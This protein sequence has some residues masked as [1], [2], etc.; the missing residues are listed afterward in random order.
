[1]NETSLLGAR[2]PA[3]LGAAILVAGLLTGC[4]AAASGPPATGDPTVA[5]VPTSAASARVTPTPAAT[6]A[7]KGPLIR[8]DTTGEE[9]SRFMLVW[10]KC[11]STN[12]VPGIT[13]EN[14]S[15]IDPQLRTKYSEAWATCEGKRPE[16]VTERFKREHPQAFQARLKKFITCMKNDGQKIIFIPPDGWGVSDEQAEAGY[17][18]SEQSM[19][20]C[21]NRAYGR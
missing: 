4:S 18:P 7:A 9:I 21:E 15:K 10:G 16:L 12:G 14:S 20:K 3:R 5:S 11:L 17:T 2:K 6:T 8:A 13:K 19:T 1:M